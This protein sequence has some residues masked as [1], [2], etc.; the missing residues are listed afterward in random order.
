MAI[1]SQGT[2]FE[3]GTGDGSSKNISG[4]TLGPVTL[5]KSAGHGLKVGDVVQFANIGGT[6]EL[7]GVKATVLAVS[8]DTIY[9]PVDSSA[10]TTYTS[11]GMATALEF[12]NIGEVV[13]WDG[14]NGSANTINATHLLSTK[15]EKLMGLPDEGQFSLSLNCVNSDAGQKACRASR[16][17]RARRDFRVS[18]KDGTVQTF[19]GFV[20]SFATSGAVDGKVDA[21]MTIEIDGEVTMV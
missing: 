10:F 17:A 21:S 1:E 13:S 6:T 2:K 12:T 5:V 18:Y 4:L 11:G 3:I 20:S 16:D 9:V 7:N 15:K 19:N 14:P 8:I